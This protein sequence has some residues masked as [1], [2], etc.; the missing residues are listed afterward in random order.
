M[1]VNQ[2]AGIPMG[3]GRAEG[4]HWVKGKGWVDNVTGEVMIADPGVGTTTPSGPP[5]GPPRAPSGTSTAGKTYD[6]SQYSA[7][8]IAE[9]EQIVNDFGG[10]IGWP[11]WFDANAFVKRLLEQ[12]IQADTQN[13]YQYLWSLMSKDAQKANP[14]A[15]FGLTRQQY[16]EKLNTLA[17]QFLN[18]TGMAIDELPPEIRNQA[19]RHNWT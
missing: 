10:F 2:H 5:P 11:T 9:A 6:L 15:F 3:V 16:T 13:G 7:G 19:L 8:A 14:N 17:D 1:A 18:Y 4:W 12:G